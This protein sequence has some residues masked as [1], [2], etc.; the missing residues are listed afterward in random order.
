MRLCTGHKANRGII[1]I[2]LPFHYHGTRTG[3]GF[4]VTP[5]PLFT[6]WRY[7]V[8]IVQEVGWAPGP[9]WRGA[10]NLAPTGIR[11]PDPPA[12]SQSLYRLRY[13]A[14]DITTV[15]SKSSVL[16]MSQCWTHRDYWTQRKLVM[17]SDVSI[18]ISHVAIY[19]I[20]ELVWRQTR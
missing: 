3:W 4:S 11:S 7:P 14:H 15:W 8:P 17:H 10:K 1:G 2:A 6:P 13:P 9:V 20:L 12:R 18:V 5:W 16:K 19:F